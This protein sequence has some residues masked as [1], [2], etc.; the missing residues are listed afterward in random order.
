MTDPQAPTDSPQRHRIETN[1]IALA[2][3]EWRA[4]RRGAAATLLMAHATG[5]HGRVWDPVVRRLPGRHVLAPDLRGHG[6][7]DAAPFAGWETFGR[8]LAGLAAALDLR[9]AVGI[10]HSMGAHAL[11]QAAA[12]EPGRFSQ[13]VLIDPVLLAPTEYLRP[14][15]PAG[16]LHPAAGRRNRFASPQ[17][18]F[19]RFAGRQP[20]ALFDRQVLHA[21]CTHALRPAADGEG[22]ELA[23]APAFEA[24][25]YPQAHGN[26]GVYAS[27]RA[28]RIPVLVVRARDRDLSVQPWDP[29]GSP[30]W[31]EVAAEFRHGIDLHFADKTHFLP[32]EDPALVAQVVSRLVDGLVP[33]GA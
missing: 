24:A 9:D 33:A 31:A 27:I 26:P 2:C 6:G 13:L 17:A 14:A 12:F 7:S 3:H 32:M 11:V 21:Y 18:M 20:Y 15:I 29:L 8:D 16:T 4:D 1:G 23:C 28:L 25:V 22:F 5:F 10:G 30:T 19:D